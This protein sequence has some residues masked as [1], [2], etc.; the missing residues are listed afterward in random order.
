MIKCVHLQPLGTSLDFKVTVLPPRFAVAKWMHALTKWK[1]QYDRLCEWITLNQTMESHQF[2]P[3]ASHCTVLYFDR[4]AASEPFFIC[5][6]ISSSF[7]CT[8][9]S[10]PGITFLYQFY[11]AH[12]DFTADHCRLQFKSLSCFQQGGSLF[13]VNIIDGHVSKMLWYCQKREM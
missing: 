1:C 3:F 6:Y 2:T 8:C 7:L 13:Y 4:D 11:E 10:S 9:Y 5:I 12:L